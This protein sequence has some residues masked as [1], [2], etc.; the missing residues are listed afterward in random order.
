[1]NFLGDV[2]K[3]AVNAGSA[4]S[5]PDFDICDE[6]FM[7]DLQKLRDLRSFLTRQAMSLDSKID[8]SFGSL[9][10]LRYRRAGRSP[11]FGEWAEVERLTQ[12][13]FGLL[14]AP[15]RHKF[16]MGAIPPWVTALPLF[17]GLVACS[18]LIW[19][20]NLLTGRL[21]VHFEQTQKTAELSELVGLGGFV[22]PYY[23]IWLAALGATGSVA[24]IGINALSIQDDATFDLTNT[25]LMLL[26]IAL[27]ALFAVVLTLPFGFGGYL[28]FAYDLVVG[29]SGRKADV[30]T[31]G[32]QAILLL[33]PF[34]LGFSTTV[35]IMVLNQFVEAIQSFF[36]RKPNTAPPV[37]VAVPVVNTDKVPTKV[38]TTS[39]A[40][41]GKAQAGTATS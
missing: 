1:V 9:N 25:K 41:S 24:F 7:R 4:G 28:S 21:A 30:T 36:G 14:P 26:R 16:L 5:D 19:S 27:G 40:P 13:L 38:R 29:T 3:F 11:S 31:L 15:M 10:Q 8:L 18:A 34:I 6:Y 17:L 37:A 20:I 22:L 2:R 33:L 32:T 39:A 35:V 12:L 23:V